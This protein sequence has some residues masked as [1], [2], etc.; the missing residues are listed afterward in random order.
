M[1]IPCHG[2]FCESRT[3]PTRCK[4][5]GQTIFILQCNCG[6]TAVFDH[7]G[8]PWPKHV[9]A[10]WSGGAG[11][12]TGPVRGRRPPKLPDAWTKGG[13]RHGNRN[14]N[15]QGGTTIKRV[16]PT[17]GGRRTLRAVV[18]AL[19]TDTKLTKKVNAFLQSGIRLSNLDPRT[20]YRQITLVDNRVRPNASYTALIPD[21]LTRG[22]CENVTA[23]AEIRGMPLNA[24][25][26]W[27]V[28]A[29]SSS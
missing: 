21:G 4:H 10:G 8:H 19:H 18:S 23:K 27:I 28:T 3:Y 22:L 11:A 25:R 9:C 15:V 12:D 5:C 6:S 29:I 16:D 1:S 2:P 20:H 14:L 7:L 13:L 26:C 17:T 24:M